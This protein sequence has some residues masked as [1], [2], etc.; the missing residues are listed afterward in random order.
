M[1]TI[2]YIPHSQI[3][4]IYPDLTETDGNPIVRIELHS[5]IE[6]TSEGAYT[7]DANGING[8]FIISK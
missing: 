3:K 1:E 8:I 4:L 7:T 5:N 2:N 6:Y